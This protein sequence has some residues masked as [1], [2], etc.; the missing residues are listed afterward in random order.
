[1]QDAIKTKGQLIQELAA[2]RKRVAELEASEVEHR[3]V[4]IER[5]PC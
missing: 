2:A 4:E 5:A 3:Q 1:M